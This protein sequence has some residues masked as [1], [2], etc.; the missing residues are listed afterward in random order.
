VTDL[1]SAAA[2][3]VGT[4]VAHEKV[5]EETDD[6]VCAV[7]SGAERRFDSAAQPSLIRILR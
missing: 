6:P 7:P 5:T 2:R 4:V 1:G 3:L